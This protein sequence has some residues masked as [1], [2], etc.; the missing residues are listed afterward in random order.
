MT[1][2][3]AAESLPPFSGD[4]AACPKCGNQGASTRYRAAKPRGLWEWNDTTILRGP[5]P[6]RLQRECDRCGFCWDEALDPV[7]HNAGPSVAECAEADRRWW[8]GEKT[9]EAP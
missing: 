1:D 7:A 6:E 4:D 2:Q 5:V 8:G 3:T 9:G